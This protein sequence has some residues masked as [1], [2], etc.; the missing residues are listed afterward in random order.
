MMRPLIPDF[1]SCIPALDTGC[2]AR[3]LAKAVPATA[4]AAALAARAV[5]TSLE[6]IRLA[7]HVQSSRAYRLALAQL[8]PLLDL[9]LSALL[10]DTN[11]PAHTHGSAIQAVTVAAWHFLALHPHLLV[12]LWKAPPRRI[13]HFCAAVSGRLGTLAP[14]TTPLPLPHIL[15]SPDA[16][17]EPAKYRISIFLRRLRITSPTSSELHNIFSRPLNALPSADGTALLAVPPPPPGAITALTVPPL[18]DTEPTL[19]LFLSGQHLA[20]ISSTLS[21]LPLVLPN[22]TGLGNRFLHSALHWQ[23]KKNPIRPTW[24]QREASP[25][26]HF[27]PRETS[28]L[29]RGFQ[30]RLRPIPEFHASR[31]ISRAS[32]W[33]KRLGRYLGQA[34]SIIL[35]GRMCLPLDQHEIEPM[36]RPNLPACYS[37]PRHTAFVD[38]IVAE[39]LVTNVVSWYPSDA[40]PLCICPLSVV[41]K[42]T[43]PFYRLVID[44]RG[45]NAVTSRWPSNMKSLA[46][47]SHI[48]K[49]GSVCFTLDIGKAYVVSPWQGCRR[50]LTH[51][52]RSDGRRYTHIGCTPDD[53]NLTCSKGMLG[54]RW[55][56]HLFCF[57]APMF[58]AR[59]SGNLLDCL[60][61]PIDRWIRSRAVPSLRWVDDYII[62]IPPLPEHQHDT[63]HCGGALH[64][65]YMCKTTMQR[66]I[67][68]QTELYDLLED[69][70]FTFNE[71][72][73]PPSQRGEFLGLGWDCLRKTFRITAGKA[74]KMAAS[75]QDML[76]TGISSRRELAKLR[77]KLIWFSPCLY[78]VPLLTRAMNKFIGSPLD[79]HLWDSRALLPADV[80]EELGHWRDTLATQAEHERPMWRL[81][82]PQVLAAYHAGHSIV[83]AYIETDAS[84]AGWGAQLRLYDPRTS[85]WTNHSTSVP[86]TVN[87]PAT[88]VHCEAEALHQVLLTY[89]PLL[90]NT[91]VL[92]VSDCATVIG[93]PNRGSPASRQ[94]QSIARNIWQL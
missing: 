9:Q 42:K 80:K 94:L 12:H 1:A 2:D 73:S 13:Q 55:R 59:C 21:L 38:A 29:P 43:H 4:D 84:L 72:R 64:G 57:L 65:C 15:P 54:F 79:P 33:K 35:D 78:S 28:P 22:P 10:S 6:P 60:L 90:Q 14:K 53:C 41:P 46:S 58:G 61:D 66:A 88:Q 52:V 20:A 44:A 83:Q 87:D 75:A 91:A 16:G 81:S 74:D 62:A 77:G 85:A 39:Y 26:P 18:A 51:R 82:P 45:P 67:A 23:D 71:K 56:S 93:L 37:D 69:L 63:T 17:A 49:P 25:P 50:S 31:V 19:T 40:P 24:A 89:L 3:E 47:S 86:W 8:L 32:R 48:F 7:I 5:A 76:S 92:H 36:D 34:A 70:G 30:A 68:F 11:S 27:Q